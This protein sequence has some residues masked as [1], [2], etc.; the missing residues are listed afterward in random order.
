MRPGDGPSTT[1]RLVPPLP[2]GSRT[3]AEPAPRLTSLD[4]TTI[5]LVANAKP[6]SEELLDDLARV[7]IE[8]Y[9]VAGVLRH[10]KPHPSLPIED[11]VL[12]MFAEQAHAV[13]TAIGD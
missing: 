2:W 8:R 13:L 12:T 3:N 1:V 4:G 5:A 6:N 10:T 11:Q 7:L 9:G